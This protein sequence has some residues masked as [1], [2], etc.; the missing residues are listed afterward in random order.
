MKGGRG[1]QF[2]KLFEKQ[3]KTCFPPGVWVRGEGGSQ[4]IL[5]KYQILN[6]PLSAT[7]VT[8]NYQNKIKQQC[9]TIFH[10]IS[11]QGKLKK[12]TK[13]KIPNNI[14]QNVLYIIFC[15]NKSW[16]LILNINFI[17]IFLGKN[18]K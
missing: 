8:S 14:S 15:K 3:Y 7:R 2:R 13:T 9:K 1:F 17:N 6:L 10:T 12:K 5:L 4:K 18:M 11:Y 16:F